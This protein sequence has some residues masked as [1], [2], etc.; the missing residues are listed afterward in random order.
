MISMWSASHQLDAW[1]EIVRCAE[2]V[3]PAS[4]SVIWGGLR[5]D[6]RESRRSGVLRQLSKLISCFGVDK[7]KST[8]QLLGSL[9]PSFHEAEAVTP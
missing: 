6:S 7:R 9:D 8:A 3:G 2:G 4:S 5:L 1:G